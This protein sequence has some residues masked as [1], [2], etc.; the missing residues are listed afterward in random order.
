MYSST[1]QNLK[2]EA[3]EASGDL[4]VTAN[5]AGRKV[6]QFIDNASGELSQATKVVTDHVNEKPVQSAL[7]ALGIGF[8]VSTLLRRI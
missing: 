1:A 7:I 8:V 2:R 3:N 6:R 4:R 5:Q